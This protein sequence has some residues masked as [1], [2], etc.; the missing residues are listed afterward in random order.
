MSSASGPTPQ[1][2]HGDSTDSNQSPGHHPVKKRKPTYLVRKEE[3][4]ALRDELVH[5]E[6]Q[7]LGVAA[8]QSLM[9]EGSR[10]QCSHPLCPRICF[11]KDWDERRATLVA[12]WDEKLQNA[13]N[14]VVTRSLHMNDG[15][16]RESNKKFETDGGD[17]C[18]KGVSVIHFPG[19]KSLRQVFE[20]LCFYLNNMEISISERLGHITVRDDYDV[21]EGLAFNSRITSR[22][23]NGITTESN[24]IVLMQ[25]FEDG[26]PH[27]GGKPCAIV[28]SDCV[29]QDERYPYRSSD[30]V[31][32]DISGAIL[33]TA[34]TQ[35]TGNDGPEGGSQSTDKD[36]IV[37]AMHRTGVLKLHRPEFPM[38]PLAQQ[39][40]EDGIADWVNVMIKTMREV[41]HSPT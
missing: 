12:I 7:Q 33:L 21:I 22:D 25:I 4:K 36:E 39:E 3:E 20:A 31:R 10:T 5:L 41:L 13:Y 38:S 6:A 17:I 18:F 24:T 27:F 26:D 34:R 19:V 2:A 32:K 30:H 11:K 15:A 37:V 16:D 14:D 40:M 23:G 8:A 29:D 9:M 35:K 1:A 28:A